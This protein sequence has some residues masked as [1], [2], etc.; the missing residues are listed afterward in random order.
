MYFC[1]E[2][3]VFLFEGYI[4][5]SLIEEITELLLLVLPIAPINQP[6]KK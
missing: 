4:W 1:A 5:L 6:V 2:L 3:Q